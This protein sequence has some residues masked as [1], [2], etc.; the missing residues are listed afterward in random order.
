MQ[1]YGFLH[2]FLPSMTQSGEPTDN[3]LAERFNGIFKEEF[4]FNIT[5]QNVKAVQQAFPKSVLI[6]N[7]ERPHLALTMKTPHQFIQQFFAPWGGFG[8]NLF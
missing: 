5:F 6:Y 7:T 4:L 8:V 1:H 3:P 2:G